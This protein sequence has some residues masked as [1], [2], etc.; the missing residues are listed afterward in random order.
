MGLIL[1]LTCSEF[2][3]LTARTDEMDMMGIGR[4]LD[5][6]LCEPRFALDLFEVS[7]LEL[8]DD[9][10]VPNVVPFDFTSVEGASDYVDPHISFDSMF[11]FVTRYDNMSVEYN[12]D[13]SVF[14][15]SHVVDPQFCPSTLAFI[16]WVSH[17]PIVLI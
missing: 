7:M 17:S 11:G 4:I 3:Y 15:Y 2:L 1:I 5:V 16:L 14:E 9:G 12:N 13:I 10:S 6:A 8:D